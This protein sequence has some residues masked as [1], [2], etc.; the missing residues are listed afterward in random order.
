MLWNTAGEHG[1]GHR[2]NDAQAVVTKRVGD[3][4][5]FYCLVT[6]ASHLPAYLNGRWLVRLHPQRFLQTSL[7]L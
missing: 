6:D 7:D 2:V 4:N 1:I 5:P 3:A